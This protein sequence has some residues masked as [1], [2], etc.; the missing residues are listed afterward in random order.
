[1]LEKSVLAGQ[2]FGP[3]QSLFIIADLSNVWVLADVY[4]QD[5][6]FVHEGQTAILEL[7]AFPGETFEGEIGLIYPSLSDQTRTLKVR[8]DFKNPEMK[9]RPG[10][11]AQVEIQTDNSP[12]LSAPLDAILDGGQI[13]YAF[14]VHNKIHFE[15]RLVTTGRMSDD[16]AEI[17]SGLVEGEE[18]VTSANFLI[19]S[20]SRLKAA[21]SGMNAMP[22]MPGMSK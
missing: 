12:V 10:M 17:L 13:K 1:V 14:V 3:D 15:P 8:L 4:E 20:E 16:Y 2:A 21:V 7:T 11:Y 19:D 18:I 5:I 9:L 22:D 6:P